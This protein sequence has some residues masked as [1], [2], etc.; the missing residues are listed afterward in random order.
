MKRVKSLKPLLAGASVDSIV[1]AVV[2]RSCRS[3]HSERTE[4]PWYS[5]VAPISWLVE[6]DVA[7]ARNRMNLSHWDEYTIEKRQE[8]LGRI[9]AAIRS[10]Q[11]PPVRYTLIHPGAKLSPIE[12]DQLYQWSHAERRRL[13]SLMPDARTDLSTASR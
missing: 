6:S 5:Y 11:M 9:G 2:E 12:R 4:W 13:K 1:L 3:C 10:R 8:L 7:Q